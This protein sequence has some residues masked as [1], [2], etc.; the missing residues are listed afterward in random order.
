MKSYSSDNTALLIVD[1]FNDFL[2]EGGKQ[3]ALTKETVKGV[4]LIENLKDILSAVRSSGIKVV[5]VPH[6]QTKKGTM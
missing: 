2:S 4:N 1:P 6:H 5:Y 3:W